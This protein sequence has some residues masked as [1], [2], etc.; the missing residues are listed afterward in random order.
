MSNSFSKKLTLSVSPLALLIAS[1]APEISFAQSVN[2]IDEIVVTARKKDESLQDVPVAV[3]ALGEEALDQLGVDTFED[4]LTQLPS[5][6]AGGQARTKYDL[7]SW[8]GLHYTKP[9]N[10]WCSRTCT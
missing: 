4:Y 10:L 3:S 7:Y 6:T 1:G 2:S 9:Y 8:F 5:V